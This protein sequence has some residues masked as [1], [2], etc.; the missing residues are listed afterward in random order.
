MIEQS[1]INEITG[2]YDTQYN[3]GTER[4]RVQPGLSLHPNKI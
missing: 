4:F 2:S 1:A 3:P